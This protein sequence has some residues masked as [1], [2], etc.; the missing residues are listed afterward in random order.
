MKYC[1]KCGA[2]L[3]GNEE[4]CPNCKIKFAKKNVEKLE[5]TSSLELPSLKKDS[6]KKKVTDKKKRVTKKEKKHGTLIKQ[7][8]LTICALFLTIIEVILLIFIIKEI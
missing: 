2:L 5:F 7:I 1:P 3:N 4:A 6:P 8:L